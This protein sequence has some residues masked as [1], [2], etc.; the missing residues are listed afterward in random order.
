[1]LDR[2]PAL[3]AYAASLAL[4][5]CGGGSND[6]PPPPSG[7]GLAQRTAAASATAQSTTNACAPIRPYYWEIGDGQQRLASGSVAAPGNP[8]TYTASTFMPIASASKWLYGAYVAE[9]RGGAL[10]SEDIQ[11]LTFRSGYT[12]L[13]TLG[14]CRADDTVGDCVARGD[15][16]VQTPAH[17]GK[18]YYNGAHMQKHASLPAPGMGLGALDGTALATEMR[19]LLGAD[20]HFTYGQPQL[21]GAA[22]ST[23]DDY[24]RFLRKLLQGELRLGALLGA[25]KVCTN[26]AT[27]AEAISTPMTNGADWNYSLG[28]WVEDDPATGDGAYSSAGGLGFYPWIDAGRRWYGIVARNGALGGGDESAACG[29]L[30][31][32]AWV[33]G[34]AR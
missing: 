8:V 16:D 1:M 21:A 22:R 12:S 24:A 3:A 17:V 30:I 25:H 2:R 20:I 33:T 7:P 9:R 6:D 31:R 32:R 29:A 15:N 11:F 5:A 4:A 27:C 26:P 28:H 18:Y 19:R 13:S 14:D 34:V 10:T 23:A